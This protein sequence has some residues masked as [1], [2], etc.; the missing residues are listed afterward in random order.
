MHK[1]GG[2]PSRRTH[3]FKDLNSI[4]PDPNAEPDYR[5][6]TAPG[7]ARLYELP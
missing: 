6:P 2:T 7:L 1:C 3:Y 4:W 5:E